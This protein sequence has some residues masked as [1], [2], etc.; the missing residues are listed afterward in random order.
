MPSPVGQAME[1]RG[2]DLPT[3]QGINDGVDHGV[4]KTEQGAEGEDLLDLVT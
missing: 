1:G 4:D 3:P 2:A